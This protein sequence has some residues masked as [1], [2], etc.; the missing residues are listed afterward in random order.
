M[1][2]SR[3]NRG[4]GGKGGA[5]GAR[6]DPLSKPKGA[7]T[8]K[9][10]KPPSD[11]ELAAL[12]E[13]RILPVLRDLQS[14]EPK[15]RSAAAAA[16]AH[17]VQDARCRKLLLREQVVRVLL[18]ETLTDASLEGRAAGWEILRVLAAEEQPDFCVHLYR[19]DVVTA[20]QHAAR[21]VRVLG[22][23]YSA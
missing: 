11:P 10:V 9:P 3:R 2:K 19:V 13:R 12:R 6:P 15:A 4:G 14:S 1:G 5:A 17:I 16:V 21:K 23:V 8:W 18:D 20:I 22:F 7:A